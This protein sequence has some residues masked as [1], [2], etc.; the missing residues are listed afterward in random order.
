[1]QNNGRKISNV[2]GGFF[3]TAPLFIS[4]CALSIAGFAC[5]GSEKEDE[6]EPKN[7][8]GIVVVK[9][10]GVFH[11][12]SGIIE[13]DSGI[14]EDDAGIVED[15]A[16]IADAS[17]IEDDAGII[18]AGIIED[19]GGIIGDDGGVIDIDGSVIEPDA[20]PTEDDDFIDIPAGSFTFTLDT[21][22]HH[23]G[24]TVRV[25]A[26]QLGRT[27]VTVEEFKKCVA[28]G[29]C[30]SAYYHDSQEDSHCNYGNENRKNHPMNCVEWSGAKEYCEW[31]G[32]R[33]PTEEE[34]EYAS[35][36]IGKK[37][38]TM[39][40]PWGSD[41]PT[42]S[43]ANYNKNVGSTTDVGH[44]SPAGDSPLGL[45]D[46]AGNVY[47]WTSSVFSSS[48]GG[49]V[50]KG[51]SYLTDAN[52]LRVAYRYGDVA[53][54]WDYSYGFRCAKSDI[55][56]ADGG[57]IDEDGGVIEPDA[58]PTEDDDFID[59]PAG[60]F[61]FTLDTENHHSGDTVTVAAF[62]LGRTPVTVEE[63][64]KC[65]ASGNC[66]SAYYQDFQENSLCNYDNESRKNHPMNCVEWSGAKEYCEW[67]GGRLPTEEEWEY[68][69]T[70]IGKKRLTMT[71]PWGDDTPTSS[72]ANYNKNVGSTT[73][74][75]HYSPAGDS[76]LG[77]VD[78]AGNVYEWTSS[79]F[80]SSTG[81]YVLKG[82]SLLSEA[83]RL[84]VVYRYGDYSTSRYYDYGLRCAK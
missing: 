48:T 34:W 23:S 65:V 7:D 11:T 50:L 80:S 61:T 55:I 1:M 57:I 69:S 30:R 74:V 9:D 10:G 14:T 2:P 44:Y 27:P 25:A 33:L 78:M 39:T 4:A 21:E 60:S 72:L 41:T 32:G 6:P 35:T 64:E 53:T 83:N 76:P 82:G 49:Y 40:Y 13:S 18:D 36:H 59:I 51:G 70:H 15:D 73:E 3:K 79:V 20:G 28:S 17:I 42:S 81:G 43:L 71:Y 37:R 45:V 22:N 19:D 77:L 26:F 16:G 12:D 84:R 29:N 67:A 5:G 68:A 24:D 8:A 63:F 54:F 52:R 58:G 46:M 66:R 56:E 38:L 31:A 47:E 75:G 62:Q